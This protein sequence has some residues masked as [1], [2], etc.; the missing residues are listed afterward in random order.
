MVHGF[1]PKSIVCQTLIYMIRTL[2]MSFFL[3][4]CI[5]QTGPHGTQAIARLQQSAQ[6]TDPFTGHFKGD[7]AEQ[8]PDYQNMSVIM[9]EFYV[10]SWRDQKGKLYRERGFTFRSKKRGTDRSGLLHP[11]YMKKNLKRLKRMVTD[12]KRKLCDLKK[13][14]SR[15]ERANLA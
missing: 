11:S 6:Q 13:K 8:D 10:M 4:I 14:S 12:G 7:R 2:Y 3:W 5:M 9:C 1:G 15:L